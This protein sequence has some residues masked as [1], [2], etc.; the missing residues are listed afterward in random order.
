MTLPHR[1]R[2]IMRMAARV[3]RKTLRRSRSTT[4]SQSSSV[5]RMRR[6][7]LMMPALFTRTSTGPNASA[8][9][10]NS[11][12]TSSPLVTSPCSAT[13]CDPASSTRLTTSA[14]ASV[15]LT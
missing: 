5:M 8:A 15:L 12:S 11:R 10:V 3:Q 14:A 13:A 1:A 7:S 4:L 9:W 6:E 2:T